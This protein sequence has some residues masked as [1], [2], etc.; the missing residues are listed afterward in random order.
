MANESAGGVA[1][2]ELPEAESLVPRSR[3]S[4]GTV[5]GDDLEEANAL[6]NWFLLCRGC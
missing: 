3:Q 1:A 6:V 4:V 2:G 5:R